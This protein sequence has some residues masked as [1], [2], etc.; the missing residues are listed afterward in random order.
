MFDARQMLCFCYNLNLNKGRDY[1]VVFAEDDLAPEVLAS[2]R[3]AYIQGAVSAVDTDEA[4]QV[5]SKGMPHMLVSY[6]VAPSDGTLGSYCYKMLIDAGSHKLFFFKR[7]KISRKFGIGFLV[8]DL[9][10]IEAAVN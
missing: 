7:H 9:K 6:V 5:M 10:K 1:S 2:A 8:E 3:A 4:D